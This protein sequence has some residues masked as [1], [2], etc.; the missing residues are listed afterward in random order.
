[1]I[2]ILKSDWRISFWAATQKP[3]FYDVWG[4]YWKTSSNVAFQFRTFSEKNNDKILK[5]PKAL[6]L[7]HFCPWRI[8][9]KFRIF[10]KNQV[11]SLL[12]RYGSL[13]SS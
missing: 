11:P 12:R 7:D 2:L 6:F 3:E 8:F 4:L 13:T 10:R 1:M 9:P 5:V